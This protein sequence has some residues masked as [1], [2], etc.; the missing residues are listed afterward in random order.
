MTTELDRQL[1]RQAASNAKMINLDLDEGARR[2]ALSQAARRLRAIA[3]LPPISEAAERI[4]RHVMAQMPLWK[5][6]DGFL[7]S[8]A[9]AISPTEDE[10]SPEIDAFLQLTDG[11]WDAV[12][13]SDVD[14]MKGDFAI[15]AGKIVC[16]LS[17]SHARYDGGVAGLMRIHDDGAYGVRKR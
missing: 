6:H 8:L 5:D 2:E 10:R 16:I 9:D 15:S 11:D 13:E 4:M 3:D 7:R 1:V 12:V 17:G 14:G